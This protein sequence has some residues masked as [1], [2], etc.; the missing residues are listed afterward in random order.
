MSD[1][2]KDTKVRPALRK[3]WEGVIEQFRKGRIN[4]ERSLQAVFSNYLQDL[5]SQ[6]DVLCEPQIL[7]E[8]GLAIPDIVVTNARDL[9][10]ATVEIKF[11]PHHYP[12]FEDDIAKL[13]QYAAFTKSFPLTLNPGT[14]RFDERQYAFHP[15][16]ILGFAVIGRHDAK[17]VDQATLSAQAGLGERFLALTYGVGA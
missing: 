17:A 11:V 15:A 6:S 9:V 14:G 2:L 16:S 3:A 8:G 5:L 7:L 10:I 4:T 13:K 12:V 1:M